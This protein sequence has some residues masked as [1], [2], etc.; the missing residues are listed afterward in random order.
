MRLDARPLNWRFVVPGEPE[1]LLFLPISGERLAGAIVPDRTTRALHEAL[2]RGSFPAVAVPDV[3][4]WARVLGSPSALIRRLAESV[5]RGGWLYAGFANAL[6]PGRPFA[7]GSLRPGSVHRCFEASDGWTVERF[8]PLPDHR[9]PA[10]LVP[11]RRPQEMDYFLRNLFVPYAETG[12]RWVTRAVR[13]GLMAMRSTALA[14]PG[15]TRVRLA[16]AIA[17]VARRSS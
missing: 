5:D 8:F 12:N 3:G 10:Y 1:G 2:D 13:R 6:F 17:I 4:S 9:C 15:G 7:P 11:A 14:S 16:P